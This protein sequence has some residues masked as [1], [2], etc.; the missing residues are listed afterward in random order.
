M[1]TITPS[2]LPTP[3]LHQLLVGSIGPR[4]ICFASTIS[5]DGVPNLAPYSFFNVFSSNPPTMIFSSN[6]RVRTNT[7]KDT[8]HNVE[9]TREVVIN[10]VNHAIVHQMALTSVE[11]P[12]EVSEFE[13]AG[14]TPIES[15]LVRPFRV[16]ESPVQYE[17]VVKQ[18]LPLGEHGGAGN[19]IICE[20]VKIHLHE[21]IFDDFGK[22]DPHKIDLMGR[23]GRA[24]YCR[25]SGNN[26][27]PIVQD[28]K[29]LGIGVENLPESIRNSR[30]LTGNNLAQ[31]ASVA[32]IPISD[33]SARTDPRVINALSSPSEKRSFHLHNYA[34]ALLESGDVKRAWQVLLV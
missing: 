15:D 5:E 22:L 29:K 13:K 31:L 23:L 19:L 30:V 1:R 8:L 32:E 26:V 10:V 21:N 4:P 7:T 12:S 18:I 28:V 34:K 33:N 6:R 20:V 9:A 25:A 3:E 17:C 2:E 16:K 11:Y 14:L 24:F 27:Y